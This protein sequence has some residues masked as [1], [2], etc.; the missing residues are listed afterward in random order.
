VTVV[1][2]ADY[3]AELIKQNSGAPTRA[4]PRASLRGGRGRE[5]WRW[6]C[7]LAEMDLQG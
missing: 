6:T 3:V 4:A 1:Q 5:G 2:A 7:G